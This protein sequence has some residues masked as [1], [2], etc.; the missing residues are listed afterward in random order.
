MW[1]SAGILIKKNT[2]PRLPLLALSR[3]VNYVFI[4][5]NQLRYSRL[6]FFLPPNTVDWHFVS[7]KKMSNLIDFNMQYLRETEFEETILLN[8]L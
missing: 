2:F 3:A 7:D 6:T 1:S 5:Y 4:R 8:I